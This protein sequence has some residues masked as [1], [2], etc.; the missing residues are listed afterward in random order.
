[1]GRQLLATCAINTTTPRPGPQ[2]PAQPLAAPS[3]DSSAES[4]GPRA[5]VAGKSTHAAQVWA[6]GPLGPARPQ[7][8]ALAGRQAGGRLRKPAA[9]GLRKG[10]HQPPALPA[11]GHA[12]ARWPRPAPAQACETAQQQPQARMPPTAL[13]CHRGST[14][15]NSLPGARLGELVPWWDLRQL[16][17]M[18]T[19]SPPREDSKQ[20]SGIYI[21]CPHPRNY[22]PEAA[23]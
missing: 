12:E 16:G 13:A 14:V 11:S 8:S 4:S 5:M 17:E 21:H 15:S 1:M 22:P 7:A 18:G 19:P 2:T 9:R 23:K 3:P 10:L 6:S 20:D